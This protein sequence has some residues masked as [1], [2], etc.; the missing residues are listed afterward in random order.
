MAHHE[1][2]LP[3][4]RDHPVDFNDGRLSKGQSFSSHHSG[5]RYSR[6]AVQWDGAHMHHTHRATAA[7]GSHPSS[8]K[9]QH[10]RRS[11]ADDQSYG[12]PSQSFSFLLA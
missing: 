9:S 5:H 10:S 8:A 12:W 1:R 2:P 6:D 4:G 7:Y 11:L 3:V